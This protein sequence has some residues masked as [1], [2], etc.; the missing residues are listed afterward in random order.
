MAA[1]PKMPAAA[2]ES[3]DGT[4]AYIELL[5]LC[6][7]GLTPPS[8]SLVVARRDGKP[9]VVPVT[10]ET[11]AEIM[12]KRRAW[13]ATSFTMMGL[14]RTDNLQACVEDVLANDVPGDMIETGVWRG[15]ATIFMRAVLKLHGVTDRTVV[16]ADSFEGVPP[17]DEE[18]FPADAGSRLYTW[19]HLAVSVESVKDNFA[20]F[21]LLDD[22]VEFV[23]GRF[24]DT[25]PALSDRVWSVVRLDGDLYESTINALEELYPNLSPGGY[26]IVDDYGALRKCREAVHD[27]RDAHGIEEEIHK[28]DWTGAF[29]QKEA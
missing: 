13:P 25:L 14:D 16:V 28:I 29:W 7:N 24:R 15:G 17:P 4:K 12:R 10:A 9:K 8:G 2:V 22:Q 3:F 23:Q 5:K 6:L 18:A 1:R 19:D 20:R 11:M 27:Y 21:G 26:L